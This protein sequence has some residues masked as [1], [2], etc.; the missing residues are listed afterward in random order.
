[1]LTLA[2]GWSETGAGKAGVAGA[3]L[4][5]EL[6]VYES[7]RQIL[8]LMITQFSPSEYASSILVSD[9]LFWWLFLS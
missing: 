7:T 9:D 6:T 2:W 3:G 8:S 5:L 1:M 4:G